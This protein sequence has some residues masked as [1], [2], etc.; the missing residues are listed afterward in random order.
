MNKQMAWRVVVLS[1]VLVALG[2]VSARPAHACPAC[3]PACGDGSYC[4]VFL[5]H[6]QCNEVCVANGESCPPI[7]PKAPL[8]EATPIFKSLTQPQMCRQ[9]SAAIPSWSLAKPAR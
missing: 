3:N 9:D 1:L 7:D 8:A 4:C 2:I 5:V 6:G